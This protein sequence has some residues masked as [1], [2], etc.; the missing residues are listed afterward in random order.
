MKF[1]WKRHQILFTTLLAVL[2]LGLVFTGVLACA[3]KQSMEA[4]AIRTLAAEAEDTLPPGDESAP[5][6]TPLP[7]AAVDPEAVLRR[8]EQTQWRYTDV[9]P[10]ISHSVSFVSKSW[11]RQ[12]GVDPAL[13]A[14]ARNTAGEFFNVYFDRELDLGEIGVDLYTD[15]QGYRPDILR[16]SNEKNDFVCVLLAED[17]SLLSA[18]NARIEATGAGDFMA[19]GQ[20]IAEYLGTQLDKEQRDH[21][22]G[23][24]DRNGNWIEMDAALK[25]ADGRYIT[26]VYDSGT[27]CALQVHPDEICMEEGVCFPAD[28]RH[29]EQVV[30]LVAPEDFEQGNPKEPAEGDMTVAE[31]THM[32]LQFM[33]TANERAIEKDMPGA[34][35]LKEGELT[36][37]IDN[38]G[39]RENYY[40]IENEWVNMDIAAKSG[41]IVRAECH[42]LYNPEMDL[43]TIDYDHMGG[44][45]YFAYVRAVA[46][47]T[48]GKD[49]VASVDVN[50]VADG[51]YCTIDPVMTDGRWYEFG[52]KDGVLEYIEHYAT[53]D[54]LVM[55]WAA[56]SLYVNT[57]TGEVFTEE[58]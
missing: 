10:R 12:D 39:Y 57:L 56:D 17:L 37:Y 43:R 42:D 23:S 3:G 13:S 38:S 32:Y 9:F 44:E 47:A 6:P 14:K 50:A 55:G 11:E 35:N 27:L 4:V 41:Y 5:T 58:R 54:T 46:E 40:H 16:L 53:A 22:G 2:A 1:Y 26:L 25:L 19:D 45:E 28:I 24:K 34:Y 15:T 8:L 33:S 18:D 48:F 36:Y 52:F 49:S 31:V 30:H 51:H 20:R 7:L 29:N 21:F